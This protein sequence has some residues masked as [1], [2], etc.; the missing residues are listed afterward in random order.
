MNHKVWATWFA[1]L[2]GWNLSAGILLAINGFIVG[3][4]IF[5]FSGGF[6]VA[7]FIVNFMEYAFLKAVHPRTERVAGDRIG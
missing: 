1:A 5:A 4:M 7:L 2:S 6:T 3:G